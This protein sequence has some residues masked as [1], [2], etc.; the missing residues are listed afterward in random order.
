MTTASDWIDGARPRTLWT[1]LSPV[2][3]GSAA[4]GALGSFRPLLALLALV[5]GL[6]LQIASN[7]ANDYADGVRGTDVNRVGPSRLVA[8]G[9][10]RP[11]AV[12]RAAYVASG[13][14]GLAGV[15]LCALSGQW[16]LLAVGAVAVVAAWAY[17][18]S[19]N[20]YGYR[21][22]GEAVVWVFF[23]PVA[24]L[25]TMVTQ[26]GTVTWWA[27][28]ASASVGLYAVALLM[29]NNIRDVEGDA[30]AGKRTVAV[31][32]G[33]RRTR[34]LFAAVVLAPVAGAVLVAFATPW[35]L[36]A[37]LA[38]LPSLIVA[39]TVWLGASGIALKPIFLGISA[40]GM[41]YGLLLSVGIALG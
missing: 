32:L 12:K 40:I 7:Y 11:S 33:E 4:A 14:G 1:S 38:T 22:W 29:V 24:V 39:V 19:S 41:G 23:G 31:R 37:T 18:A 16:W 25:G 9:R 2:L 10:A 36:L 35:A 30:L 13:V 20:P 27:V 3:V 17:T 28:I 6:A 15:E 26:A 5:V 21:G 34:R 8:S